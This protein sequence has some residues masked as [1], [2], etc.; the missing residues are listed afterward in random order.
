MRSASSERRRLR[1][2]VGRWQAWVIVAV[3][4][5]TVAHAQ[6]PFYTDDADVT[7][8]GNVHVECFDEHDWLQPSQMPHLQQNT[9]NIKVNYGLGGGLEL[10]VDGPIITIVNDPSEAVPRP[11]GLGD[12]DFGIKYNLRQERTGS[13]VPA[14]TL[15]SYIEVPTGEVST[16]L[17][18]GLGDV[19]VYTLVQKTFPRQFVGQLN[20]G[21]LFHGNTSTGT[22]GIPTARGHVVTM[23]G[24]LVR[25]ISET[26]SL[27]V[28]VTAA[29]TRNAALEREQFQVMLGG[30]F[31]LRRG[32]T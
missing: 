25:Q 9:F 27:G 12:L 11:V 19:W 30:N 31:E 3:W 4:S 16:G 8:K 5:S 32:L 6:Q 10:D 2:P 26:L 18:S 13:R 24:S 22:V 23:G 15:T 1:S 28:D 17:G 29:A 14:I 7:P 20:G 21:Y